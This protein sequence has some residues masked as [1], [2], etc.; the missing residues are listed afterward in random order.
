[1]INTTPEKTCPKF[2]L[3]PHYQ[4]CV[5]KTISDHHRQESHRKFK[6]ICINKTTQIFLNS[7]A[8]WLMLHDEIESVLH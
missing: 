1:M 5:L 4:I 2:S 8:K 3:W 7:S 6:D